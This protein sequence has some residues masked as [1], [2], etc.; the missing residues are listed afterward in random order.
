MRR[1]IVAAVAAVLVIA[2]GAT[3]ARADRQPAAASERSTTTA[4]AVDRRS[5]PIDL[6]A[7]G[8][9]AVGS[10]PDLTRP[11]VVATGLE[12]PWGLDFLPDGSALV[13]QRNQGTILRIR[14]GRPARQ[15]ARIPDVV[16]GGEAGLLGLAVSPTYRRDRWVY[17]CYTT[18]TDIRVV[19][20]RLRSDRAPQVLVSGIPR[21]TFH[22]GGRIAFGPD[23][24]LYVGV[25]DAGVPARSQDLSS[26]NGK[27]LRIRPDG[28]VPA[29]NPFP[30]SPVYSYGHRN[31]QGLAWDR[32]GRLFATEFGQSTWD[33]VNRIVPGGNYGWPIVEGVAGDPRFRDPV[34]VWP[35]AQA[36]PSGAAFSRGT[37]YV[38]ALRG[39]RLWA[40]PVDAAGNVGVP[41]AELVGTYGR[42]RTVAVAPDGALWVTTSNREPRGVPPA[43]DDDRVL[44]FPPTHRQPSA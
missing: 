15:V 29:D 40:I 11:R 2:L 44:R 13:A 32:G 16:A 25:G 39:T 4:G 26:R 12:V 19:R 38:A 31:V 36:S 33:E 8:R 23:R 18:A 35:P 20:F 27:I 5:V 22:D 41:V 42:L 43:A 30:G 34:V 7:V 10:G 28:G 9:R 3:D 17:A 14:P 24:M 6:R 21:A 1:R 37:L